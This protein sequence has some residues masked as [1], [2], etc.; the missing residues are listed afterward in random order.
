M[1][2]EVRV[3]LDTG[4]LTTKIGIAGEDNPKALVHSIAD[5]AHKVP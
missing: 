2:E 3:V 1:G 4:G 5:G